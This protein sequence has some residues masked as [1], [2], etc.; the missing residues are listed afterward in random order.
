MRLF[1]SARWL[2]LALFFALVPASSF[3]G[4]FVSVNVAPPPLPVYV[5]PPC[6][7]P[8]YMWTPGYW[9]YGDE[10]YYW[11]PGTW[12]PAPA[13]GLLW[14]PQYWGWENGAYI[15]HHG[16]WGPHVG[17]YGGVNY[18]FG[19]G[20]IGFAGGMWRGGLFS[21]NTAVV[22]VGFGGG[23]VY[24]DRGAVERGFVARDSHVAFSGGPGGIHHEA[25]R[26]ERM[27]ERDHHIEHTSFQ[28]QHE[29]AAHADRNSFAR[30]NGG[31]PSNMAVS[32]PMGFNGGH[33][34]PME[35]Q[36]QQPMMHQGQ[37][38]MEHQG[39]QQMM[40]QGQQPMNH[41]GQ[42]PMEHQGQQQMMHQGQQP[43]GH[44]G[45]QPEMRMDQRNGGN[46]PMRG[47]S[48]NYAPHNSPES[49]AQPQ[50]R[51]AQQQPQ[52]QQH[53]APQQHPAQQPQQH[54]APQQQPQ[55]HGGHEG[56]E[57]HR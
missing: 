49:H 18:G 13:P 12:V 11:V 25:G 29:F 35:H 56:G 6:P 5:Q 17:F 33:S 26:E 45:Q 43:M 21:Y 9:A 10:G 19:Y 51:P 42:Q 22:H 53:P 24:E 47:S 14:T 55:Q 57:H 48:P 16:Y 41:Q 52:Q 39:Q 36:G 3:A 38:P 23:H 2:V 32:R 44:Q 34:A 54:P 46:A 37:Q 8:G 4:V 28:Q 1:R 40:H 15:F 27:A 20:G 31:R 7:E 30:N 50:Q